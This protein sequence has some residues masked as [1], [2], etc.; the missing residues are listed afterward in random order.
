MTESDAVILII[1]G[2]IGSTGA[3]SVAIF[4]WGFIEY[5]TKIGLPADKR[6]RGIEILEWGVRFLITSIVLIG[7]L[8]VV[9]RWLGL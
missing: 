8:K 6:N 4:I 7:V 1:Y 3:L 9:S 5:I 2:L